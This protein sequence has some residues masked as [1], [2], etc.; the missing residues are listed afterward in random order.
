MKKHWIFGG[1]TPINRVV[2]GKFDMCRL[3]KNRPKKRAKVHKK[4]L[5]MPR[6]GL[7]VHTGVQGGAQNDKRRRGYC[8]VCTAAGEVKR[9]LLQF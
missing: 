4:P 2:E 8:A 1:K 6:T 7:A 9:W 5:E 3:H